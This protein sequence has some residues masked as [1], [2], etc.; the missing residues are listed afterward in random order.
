MARF[1][2]AATARRFLRFHC[3]FQLGGDGAPPLRI[4]Q[5]NWS[6]I[7]WDRICNDFQHNANVLFMTECML[8]IFNKYFIMHEIH[9]KQIRIRNYNYNSNGLYFITF[10]TQFR[11]CLLGDIHDGVMRLNPAGLMVHNEISSIPIRYV[12]VG[13]DSFVVMP[14]HVHAIIA[15]NND[16]GLVKSLPDVIRKIKTFTTNRY[17]NGI[18]NYG[19]PGFDRRLWQRGYYESI[20]RN[21]NSVKRIRKYI[22]DNPLNWH[23]KLNGRDGQYM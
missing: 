3:A 1:F 14:N 5:T 18:H 17:I 4:S 2:R 10:C 20:I 11:L 22:D 21:S 16:V 12:G 13:V 6:V 15:L 19:W 23:H 9:R 8:I 7:Y